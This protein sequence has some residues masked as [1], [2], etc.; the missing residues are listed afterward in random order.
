MLEFLLLPQGVAGGMAAAIPTF[1]NLDSKALLAA[2][3][4]SNSGYPLLCPVK[5]YQTPQ[6]EGLGFCALF[7]IC[8]K[9]LKFF[10]QGVK[11]SI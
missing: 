10:M 2:L 9:V 4:I 6:V 11:A 7:R 5:I 8:C 3:P 1:E